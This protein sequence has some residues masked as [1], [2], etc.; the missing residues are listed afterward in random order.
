MSA[1]CCGLPMFLVVVRV[2]V[3]GVREGVCVS[4]CHS[5]FKEMG[6]PPRRN[7]CTCRAESIYWRDI[8]QWYHGTSFL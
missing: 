3:L 7:T 8:T 1:G 4:V 5:P 6:G 2:V